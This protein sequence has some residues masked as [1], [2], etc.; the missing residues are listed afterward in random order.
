MGMFDSLYFKCIFCGKR[1]EAQT[2][3]GPCVL[4]TFEM[5]EDLPVWLMCDLDKDI[6]TCRRCGKKQQL[7]FD[8]K[9]KV[10]RKDIV[11]VEN[12]DWI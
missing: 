1:I 3:S 9:I 5:Q 10:K 12:L 4:D 2:K 6:V 8:L 11:P 7:I